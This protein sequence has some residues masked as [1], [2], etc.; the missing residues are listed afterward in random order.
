MLR[1]F[2]N[3]DPQINSYEDFWNWFSDNE[4]T[5]FKVLKSHDEVEKNFL[6]KVFFQLNKINNAI[7]LMA[8]MH[9]S[10][11]AEVIFSP[12]GSIKNVV[13]TEELVNA[14]PSLKRWQFTAL[15]PATF[16]A[17]I[18]FDGHIFSRR[19]LSFVVNQNENRPDEIDLSVIY[20]GIN[21]SNASSVT[22]GI[23]IFLDNFLGELNAITM[24]DSVQVIAEPE[25]WAEI[26]PME[27]LKDYLVWREKE[28]VEK[29]DG[30]RRNTEEDAYATFQSQLEDGT[31]LVALF[32]TDLLEWDAKASHPWIVRIEIAY[33]GE[34]YN[35]MPDTGEYALINELEQALMDKLLDAD[36]YLN[37]GRE[38]GDNSCEI[39]FACKEFRESSKIVS[40]VLTNFGNVLEV[41]YHIYKDKYWQ[42]LDRFR[43]AEDAEDLGDD[44][45]DEDDFSQDDDFNNN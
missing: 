29:Y 24:L 3:K 42:S 28:F 12:D 43:F 18:D 6:D 23:Y 13:F 8:G 10:E 25:A 41:D 27:K 45:E 38:T 4:K 39:Y 9:D 33:N 17:S 14:A 22:N 31:P 36:G 11:T 26:I 2:K 35:G 40:E 34:D 32:N 5:F 20:A 21:E 19:D 15:K 1:I 37:V 30:T 16:E 44:D 7:F